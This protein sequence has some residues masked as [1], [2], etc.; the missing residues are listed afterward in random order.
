VGPYAVA[1]GVIGLGLFFLIG[2]RGIRGEALYAGVGPRAFPTI[3]GAALVVLGS[4]F[5]V[6]VRRG[7]RFPDAEGPAR[8]G[9]MAW[10]LPGLALGTLVLQPAGF[11]LAAL[12]VFVLGA[13][14]FGSRR[15]ARDAV[16]GALVAV[17]VYVGFSRMLG[18]TLPGGL[19]DRF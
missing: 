13:R 5:L 10:I 17:A 12:V 16:I 6:A 9:T 2:A 7:A 19:L 1:V 14:G 18:V 11:P 8:R 4:L 15:W 3:V